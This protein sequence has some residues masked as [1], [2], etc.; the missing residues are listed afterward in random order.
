MAT[1]FLDHIG[2]ADAADGLTFANRWKTFTLGATAARIAPGD[3]IR[4]M[5]SPEQTSLAQT[6]V[7]TNRVGGLAATLAIGSSTNATPI[8]VTT[9]AHGLVAGDTVIITGHT[10]N[11]NANG[12]WRVGAVPTTTTY[13]LLRADGTNS[14]GN[15]AGGA[16]GT[17]RLRTNSVVI[18]TT[19]VNANIAETGNFGIKTNWMTWPWGSSV[20]P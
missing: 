1:F 6:G 12:T 5:G 13:E 14:V 10:V 11:T 18:L 7:W 3:I 20:S 15:G 8:V 19:A 16:T 4:V 9:A 17:H 2:G